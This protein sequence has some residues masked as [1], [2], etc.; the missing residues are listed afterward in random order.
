MTTECDVE[1]YKSELIQSTRCAFYRTKLVLG[2]GANTSMLPFLFMIKRTNV[3]VFDSCIVWLLH[4]VIQLHV[5][6]CKCLF[7]H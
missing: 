4:L 2:V 6:L 3:F 7:T 1:T 5:D